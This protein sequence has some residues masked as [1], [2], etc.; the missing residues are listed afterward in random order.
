MTS[1]SPRGLFEWTLPAAAVVF[2]VT[3]AL[4][5]GGR[6]P[7]PVATSWPSGGEPAGPTPRWMELS[8]SAFAV[9]IGA[10]FAAIAPRAPTVRLARAFVVLGHVA[11]IGWAGRLWRIVAANLDAER[12][13]DSTATLSVPGVLVAMS[14]AGLVGWLVSGPRRHAGGATDG[15]NVADR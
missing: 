8:F 6:L 12:W 13:L 5:M 7:D 1:L 2:A 11:T 14:A 3:V 9:T 15:D 10:A 4:T